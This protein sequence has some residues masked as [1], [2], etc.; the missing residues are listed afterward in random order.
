MPAEPDVLWVEF[1]L[2]D[3]KLR[4]WPEAIELAAPFD[5][6]GTKANGQAA[7]TRFS[8]GRHTLSVR[9][10]FKDGYVDVFTASFTVS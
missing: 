6:A 2:D 1:H 5:Y 8:R 4:G 10:V 3:L 9:I 7:L